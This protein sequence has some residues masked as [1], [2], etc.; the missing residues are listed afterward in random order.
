MPLSAEAQHLTIVLAELKDESFFFTTKGE[1]LSA[2]YLRLQENLNFLFTLLL[3]KQQK[4]LVQQSSC[5]EYRCHS[6]LG[7]V[8]MDVYRDV[9]KVAKLLWSD[10]TTTFS[11]TTS[12]TIHVSDVPRFFFFFY[13]SELRVAY[14]ANSIL[15][16]S[17]PSTSSPRVSVRERKVVVFIFFV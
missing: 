16:F 7:T 9:A 17:L 14:R 13:T 11:T 4:Q 8:P 12:T 1:R 5:S 15:P 3:Y 2:A 6:S 10:R